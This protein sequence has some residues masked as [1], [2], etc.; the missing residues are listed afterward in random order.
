MSWFR[1]KKRDVSRDEVPTFSPDRP[2]VLSLAP[3]DDEIRSAVTS[4]IEFMA[5]GDY[6]A[7][8][9][10]VFGKP[11]APESFRETVESYCVGLAEARQKVVEALRAQGKQ[12]NDPPPP[13][14][15]D[16]S[17]VVSAYT[18]VVDRIEIHRDGIPSGAVAWLGFPIPLANGFGIW[19]TMG[20]MQSGAK[21][22]LEFEIFHL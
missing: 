10:A 5:R 7:A 16:R 22:V 21:C 11:P 8:V 14:A 13:D 15:S 2:I 9:A 3:T 19:T 1:R 20:V 6:A 12:V 18:E 17:V 4:W